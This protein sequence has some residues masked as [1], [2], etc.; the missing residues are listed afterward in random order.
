M[1]CSKIKH[2]QRH[3]IIDIVATII[4]KTDVV[5]PV[6]LFDHLPQESLSTLGLL[7]C[8]LHHVDRLNQAL[9]RDQVS[10]RLLQ[11]QLVQLYHHHLGVLEALFLPKR[12]QN[13]RH[14]VDLVLLFDPRH[15]CK[16]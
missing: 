16:E 8:H 13:Q 9:H 6:I 7:V 14:P 5:L 3:Y 10:Q 11:D 4:K 2:D 12:H 15:P 1:R